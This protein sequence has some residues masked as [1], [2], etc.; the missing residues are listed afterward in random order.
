[1]KIIQ[2]SAEN[3]N[4]IH[5]CGMLL[6]DNFQHS[7]NNIEGAVQAVLS[8][9][10]ENKISIILVDE[11]DEVLGWICGVEQYNANVWEIQ[12]I[13]VNKE[14]QGKGIGK[15]LT[16]EFEKL[17]ALRNGVT[18]ILGVE[19]MDNGTSLGGIDI[20]PD[21]LN[22]MENIKNLK[23]HPYEFYIKMGYKIVGVVPDSNGF[24]KPDIL[25]AK[26]VSAN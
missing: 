18:I 6:I 11:N 12:P 14:Q 7:W 2:L 9:I 15:L 24:G 1:M 20:Y 5:Q 23:H 19:D 22:K 16:E 17:V 10:D 26:R 21:I 13:I 4:H 3:T 25:M 8:T